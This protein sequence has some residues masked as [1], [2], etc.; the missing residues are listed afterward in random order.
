MTLAQDAEQ[1]APFPAKEAADWIAE[2]LLEGAERAGKEVEV[3]YYCGALRGLGE[4]PTLSL[5][6]STDSGTIDL[7]E[8]R[9]ERLWVSCS[10]DS[11]ATPSAICI[12]DES[13]LQAWLDVGLGFLTC[14]LCNLAQPSMH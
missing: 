4:T 5:G 8:D 2:K 11:R 14:D 7:I 6:I 13:N 12:S 3:I 9:W 1:L 10:A